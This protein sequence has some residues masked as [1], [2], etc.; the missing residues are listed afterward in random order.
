M[1]AGVLLDG[2]EAGDASAFGEDLADTVAG[3]LGGDEG[4]VGRCWRCDGAE[5]DV[6]AV[7]E[8]E[9]DVGLHVGGDLGVVDLGGSLVGREV[10]DDVGPFA[11]VRDSVDNEA[12]FAGAVGVGRVG[13]KAYADVNAGVLEVESVGVALRAVADDGDFLCL[14]E[15]EVCVCVV[16]CLCHFSVLL[17][18]SVMVTSRDESARGIVRLDARL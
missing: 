6:E 16:V 2:D 14:D 9:G 4:D 5:A 11:D 7:R 1:A 15:R 12:G 17:S 3:A 13:A 18:F 10:H 8:H